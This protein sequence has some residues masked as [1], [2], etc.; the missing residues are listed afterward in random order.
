MADTGVR[1]IVWRN[2]DA[3][4]VL[5]LGAFFLFLWRFFWLVHHALFLLLLAV[6]I[7]VVLHAPARALSRWIPFRLAFALVLAAF[8]G[9]LAALLFRIVPQ[10]LEQATMLA[11]ELPRTLDSVGQWYKQKTGAPPDPALA[12]SVGRQAAEFAGRFVPMAFNAIGVLLGGAAVLVLAI[13]LA[14]QPELYRGL[15]LRAVHPEA[16]PQW[17]RVYDEAGRSVRAW[18]IGKSLEMLLIGVATTVGLTLF[19]VPGA[20]ALGAF[21]GLME[22]IPNVG[23]TAGAL[24]AVLAAFA[25]SPGKALGVAVYFAVQQQIAAALFLPLVERRAVNIP[26]AVLL[27]W[28]MMLA[29]GF[30]PLAL[31]VATPLLAVITVAARVLYYEPAEARHQWD[32]RD[33]AADAAAVPGAP[34]SEHRGGESQLLTE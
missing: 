7:A 8:L 16:R 26:P 10:V 21:A 29:I 18:M 14:S 31:F 9:A 34:E 27:T 32:R 3:A 23:P 2:A 17:A 19:G 20:L 30:G 1:R 22:F 28:Q 12:G 25:V 15:L 24:P 13:F 33:P 11:Q 4:R 5:A 6:L